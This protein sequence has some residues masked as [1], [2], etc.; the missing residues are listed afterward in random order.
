M[1]PVSGD[2]IG[3]RVT[4]PVVSGYTAIITGSWFHAD[5]R[6]EQVANAKLIAAAPDLLTALEY[7]IECVPCPERNCSCHIAPPCSDCVENGALREALDD[8]RAV[9]AKARSQP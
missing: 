2:Q 6:A 3:I 4:G 7:I 9:V 1:E 8:A 5:Q